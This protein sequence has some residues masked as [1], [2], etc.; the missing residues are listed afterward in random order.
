MYQQSNIEKLKSGVPQGPI[1][2][3]T[4]FVIYINDMSSFI[5][6]S[7]IVDFYDDDSTV[8]ESGYDVKLI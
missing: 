3:P 6:N 7:P 2:G 1:L 8:N 5:Q 4:I